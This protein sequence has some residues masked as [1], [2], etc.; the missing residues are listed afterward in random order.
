[1]RTVAATAFA[2]TAFAAL[3]AAGGGV[4]VAPAAYA[5]TTHD[6]RVVAFGESLTYDEATNAERYVKVLAERRDDGTVGV[7]VDGY[8]STPTPCE[9]GTIGYDFRGFDGNGTGS[10]VVGARLG[11]AHATAA[12]DLTSLEHEACGGELP[13]T[14]TPGVPVRLDVTAIAAPVNLISAASTRVAGERNE[15]VRFREVVRDAAGSVAV[16]GATS[17]TTAGSISKITGTVRGGDGSALALL[18][19][20]QQPSALTALAGAATVTHDSRTTVIAT[21]SFRYV[22]PEPVLG[23]PVVVDELAAQAETPKGGPTTVFA[24]YHTSV[25]KDCGTETL[26]VVDTFRYGN[27]PGT[28]DTGAGYRS[29]HGATTMP[30]TVDSYDSCTDRQTTRTLPAQPAAIDLTATSPLMRIDTLSS[31]VAP[32]LGRSRE[33]LRIR[34][35]LSTGTLRLGSISRTATVGA[36]GQ[37]RETSHGTT[38]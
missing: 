2:A 21:G 26:G 32:S 36:A 1:M 12:L 7:H 35:R 38:H 31:Y 5:A 15:L 37:R 29:A 24:T 33:T 13:P 23:N 27:A 8:V 11:S 17:A 14:V 3:L 9:D 10:L 16:A 25:L 20:W 30:I 19:P 28:L 18:T 6:R 22:N 34:L 4:T